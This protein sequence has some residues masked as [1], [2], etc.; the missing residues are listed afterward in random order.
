MISSK[1]Y[2]I[3]MNVGMCEM[4]RLDTH[5]LAI[6]KSLDLKSI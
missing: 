3:C 6:P 5:G 1:I 4:C 2:K